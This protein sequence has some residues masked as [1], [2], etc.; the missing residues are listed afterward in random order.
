MIFKDIAKSKFYPQHY[1]Y[2]SI[3]DDEKCCICNKKIPKSS[4][5]LRKK[6]NSNIICLIC[7][8]EIAEVD[9]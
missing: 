7:I 5:I 9:K 1:P 4:L 8:T 2:A 3:E 6:E